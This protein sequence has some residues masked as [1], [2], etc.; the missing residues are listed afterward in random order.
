MK[1]YVFHLW[2]LQQK[3]KQGLNKERS[4]F[5][6]SRNKL[7]YK[8]K[9]KK[10]LKQ[11]QHKFI[12]YHTQLQKKLFLKARLVSRNRHFMQIWPALGFTLK[13]YSLSL[14]SP[15]LMI[16]TPS[17]TDLPRRD[18]LLTH[19]PY[20]RSLLSNPEKP[21]NNSFI[22]KSV[23]EEVGFGRAGSGPRQLVSMGQNNYCY[24]A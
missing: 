20:E 4:A 5:G 13:S 21:S 23:R 12:L 19:D 17:H 3:L 8:L 18:N 16:C 1:G 10:K 15:L 7:L 2:L 9:K 11:S 22:C 14:L 6:E 24:R